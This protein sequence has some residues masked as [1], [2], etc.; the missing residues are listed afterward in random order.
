MSDIVYSMTGDTAGLERAWSKAN[1][2]VDSHRKSLLSIKDSWTNVTTE[3]DK[4]AKMSERGMTQAFQAGRSALERYR[5]DLRALH[6]E[7]RSQKYDDAP[8]S[9]ASKRD[10][11]NEA[12]TRYRA[13]MALIGADARDH[14]A[15]ADKARRAAADLDVMN[16][17]RAKALQLVLA[18]EPAL[19]RMNRRLAESAALHKAHPD[20]MNPKQFAD[21]QARIR[22][23]GAEPSAL[24]G[25]GR[26]AAGYLS[27][28]A[29]IRVARMEYESLKERQVG[30]LGANVLMGPLAQEAIFNLG[31]LDPDN[32]VT[33]A[34]LT[35]RLS[36]ITAKTG[37]PK[38]ILTA[39]SG[40]AL[41]SK[42]PLKIEEALNALEKSAE[43]APL[44][45]AD[46]LASIAYSVGNL[47]NNLSLKKPE[48]ALGYLTSV[49]KTSNVASTD[50][51]VQYVLPN[52]ASM[53]MA[54]YSA[55]GAQAMLS[56]EG[57]MRGDKVGRI[58]STAGVQLVKML[59]DRFPEL[60]PEEAEKKIRSSEY[61]F[62]KF[63][64]GGTYRSEKHVN[65]MTGKVS[66]RPQKMEG[67]AFDAK[68]DQPMREYLSPKDTPL[69]RA[70]REAYR[71]AVAP[72][73][74]EPLYHEK[75]A[76]QNTNAAFRLAR[77]QKQV[78]A[79]DELRK[80][81]D[82]ESARAGV[83]HDVIAA[84]NSAGMG[85]IRSMRLSLEF[86]AQMNIGGQKANEAARR[87]L[88]ALAVDYDTR[89]IIDT[90]AG[91]AASKKTAA[92]LRDA[93][94]YFDEPTEH[95]AWT[96][97][98]KKKREAA[99]DAAQAEI[100]RK[101]SFAVTGD[102]KNTREFWGMFREQWGI[103]GSTKSPP[104][105]VG[106]SPLGAFLRPFETTEF[107]VEQTET[108]PV[109]HLE[110]MRAKAR[111]QFN[112]PEAKA[113]RDADAVDGD[114]QRAARKL[115]DEEREK[116]EAAT[117]EAAT[118]RKWAQHNIDL[119][120]QHFLEDRDAIPALESHNSKLEKESA[121]LEDKKNELRGRMP[122]GTSERDEY[123][124]SAVEDA[125]SRLDGAIRQNTD[126]VKENNRRLEALGIR[127]PTQVMPSTPS[128]TGADTAPSSGRTPSLSLS[129]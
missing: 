19:A 2:L 6:A 1:G 17:G 29:A 128:R 118:R 123:N 49:G 88:N 40:R 8:M 111:E 120:A 86:W 60:A 75:I 57:A 89:S 78:E 61:E 44:S 94:K 90:S 55:R 54:G 7:A 116:A 93:K 28:G 100:D 56:A 106:D 73:K 117:P 102:R 20:V 110:E 121:A 77:I 69:Q 74:S 43:F 14:L 10:W 33:A 85:S 70:Y 127:G 119:R 68:A 16:A 112:S 105:S 104:K 12:R 46:Q 37:V 51:L 27:V 66:Y 59:R 9:A 92:A 39:A 4:Y 32:P 114:R 96:G 5:S 122:S 99:V 87:A 53:V 30:A 113:K 31:N 129:N 34:D 38:N 98:E 15:G 79:N 101:N 81:E 18:T 21:A 84:M 80:L 109:D 67:V 41:S 63:F 50:D 13:D 124:R 108:V 23:D 72:E 62:N 64:E 36:E 91:K 115:A 71:V 47:M 3:S 76:S 26:M 35:K 95:G 24:A 58:S 42:G 107:E 48:Q 11:R 126:V 25:I 22:A 45:T 125:I 65:R 97:E 52:I 82:T 83:M 103:G